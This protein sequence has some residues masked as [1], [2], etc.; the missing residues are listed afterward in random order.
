MVLPPAAG[1]AGISRS[2]LVADAHGFVP[3]DDHYRH[4]SWPQIYAVGV[5]ARGE[6]GAQSLEGRPKTGYLATIM[7][8]AAARA[9]SAAFPENSGPDSLFPAV[10]VAVWHSSPRTFVPSPYP[11]SVLS[12]V[13]SV[14]AGALLYGWVAW[15]TRS[16]RWTTVSHVLF[17]VAGLGWTSYVERYAAWTYLSARV[18]TGMLGSRLAVIPSSIGSCLQSAVGRCRAPHTSPCYAVNHIA[19]RAT[20]PRTGTRIDMHTSLIWSRQPR[21]TSA[22]K[23]GGRRR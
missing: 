6:D 3:V 17:D 11:G 10:G 5:A 2:P 15:R 21:L 22:M 12:F 18:R 23:I 20:K 8:R 1:V 9:V 19:R 7:A 14:G 16:I 4:V 13:G